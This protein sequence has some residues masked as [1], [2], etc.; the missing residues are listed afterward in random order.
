MF[1]LTSIYLR[2]YIE[3]RAGVSTF[4]STPTPAPP[5]IPSDSNSDSTALLAKILKIQFKHSFKQ[6]H[7]NT[8]H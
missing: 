8:D 1:I 3:L 2:F 7:A 4:L 5:K 6:Q